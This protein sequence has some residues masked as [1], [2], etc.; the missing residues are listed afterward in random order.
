[1]WSF[2]SG[3]LTIITFG[4]KSF[5]NIFINLM[6][7]QYILKKK[8]QPNQLYCSEQRIYNI[9]AVW[10]CKGKCYGGMQIKQT[11]IFS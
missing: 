11:Q 2:V 9:N 4:I 5:W 8:N 10:R 7:F 6:F 1:M 3:V